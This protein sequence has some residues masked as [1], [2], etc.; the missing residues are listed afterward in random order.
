MEKEL[1]GELVESI[2]AGSRILNGV[3]KPKRSFKYEEPDVRVI[4]ERLRL[5]QQKF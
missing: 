4:R 5:S 3:A 2:K 1:F